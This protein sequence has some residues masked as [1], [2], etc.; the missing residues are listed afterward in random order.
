[1]GGKYICQY[2]FNKGEVCERE[3]KKP[4]GCYIHWKRRQQS[5][6]KQD[7]CERPIAS[8]Y[9]FYNIYVNKCHLKVYY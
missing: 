7:R 8:K 4:E 9:G 5:L 6:Y 2:H 1:M 3:S